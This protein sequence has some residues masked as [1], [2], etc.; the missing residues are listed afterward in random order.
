[1]G[2]FSDYTENKALDFL[3]GGQAFARAAT[4]F[5]SAHTATLND[6]GSGTEVSGNGYARK[7]I[8]NNST[9]FPAAASRSK[10]LAV[11]HDFATASGS[12]GTVSDFGLWDASSSGNLILADIA[13]TPQVVSSGGTLYIPAAIGLVVSLGGDI[14]TFLGNAL[15]DHILGGP[16]YAPPSTVYLALFVSGVEVSGNGYARKAVTND[17]TN[18]PA[19]VSGVKTLATEQQFNSSPSGAWGI[20]D[21]VRIIDASSGGNTMFSKALT[22]PRTVGVNAPCRFSAGALTLTMS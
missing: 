4:L 22:T 11:Q 8:A 7:S 16:D 3:L 15:L 2:S 18:F 20:V 19:A 1:M 12:W 5:G 6:N 14:S 13:A 10:A 9:N 17:V 21:E